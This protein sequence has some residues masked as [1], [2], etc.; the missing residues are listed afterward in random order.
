MAGQEKEWMGYHLDGL[1]AR[2]NADQWT[3]AAR[4]DG[5]WCRTAG[6]GAER[7]M[8]KLTAVEKLG[9]DYVTQ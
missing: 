8:T 9:L 5:E 2:L 1:R 3:T 6:K 7:F 4:D